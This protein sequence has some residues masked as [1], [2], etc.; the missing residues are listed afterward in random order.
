VRSWEQM[1]EPEIR[2]IFRSARL[3]EKSA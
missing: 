3:R 1:R 2:E